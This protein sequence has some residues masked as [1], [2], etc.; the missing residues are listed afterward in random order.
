MYASRRYIFRGPLS[1]TQVKERCM[2]AVTHFPGSAFSLTHTHQCGCVSPEDPSPAL[3][4]RSDHTRW[5][6]DEALWEP[7]TVLHPSHLLTREPPQA[8]TTTR[9]QLCKEKKIQS[10]CMN[11]SNCL[12]MWKWVCLMWSVFLFC[13]L[14]IVQFN[15]VLWR[16]SSLMANGWTKRWLNLK[17]KK[18]EA[19][20][21]GN[22]QR[23]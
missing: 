2:W 15:D 7:C 9:F 4:G 22:C 20:F 12:Q 6:G 10:K 16:F 1:C 18:M 11:Q 5:P 3:D 8:P 14:L 13:N 19:W 17:V 21:F 23:C